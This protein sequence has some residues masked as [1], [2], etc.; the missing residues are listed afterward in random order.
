MDESKEVIRAYIV[1]QF[2][3]GEGEGLEESTS[4]LEEGV[5]DSTGILE[6]VDFISEKFS[7]SVEN[8]D[9]IPEN[10]DSINSIAAF[11]ARKRQ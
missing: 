8:D 4:F 1:N 5:I 10:L 9:L 11:I 3:F 6:L 2:L 7:I